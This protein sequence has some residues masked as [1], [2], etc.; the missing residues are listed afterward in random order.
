V[1]IL[2]IHNLQV[3][4]LPV[5]G[6]IVVHWDG[7]SYA[8]VNKDDLLRIFAAFDIKKY[9]FSPSGN[10]AVAW[11]ADIM[12]LDY[13]PEEWANGGKWGY[14]LRDLFVGRIDID[15]ESVFP[16]IGQPK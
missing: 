15:D 6:G 7:S 14:N 4:G 5:V 3:P 11:G 10:L 13:T 1:S 9:A 16:E 12:C 8:C 2:L